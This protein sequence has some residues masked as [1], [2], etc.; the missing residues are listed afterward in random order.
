[1]LIRGHRYQVLER[2]FFQF[3]LAPHEA[4]LQKVYGVGAEAIAK[5]IQSIAD[6]FRGGYGDAMEKMQAHRRGAV[7]PSL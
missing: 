4:A 5:G 2:E 1:V 6:S 7:P 3:V